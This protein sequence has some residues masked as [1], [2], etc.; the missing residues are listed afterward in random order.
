M[1]KQ[2]KFVEIAT[3]LLTEQ[4]LECLYDILEILE[5][6]HIAQQLV[7]SEK[8]P[9]VSIALPTYERLTETWRLEK[10]LK[11]KLLPFLNT[12]LDR[13]MEYVHLLRSNKIYALA[14]SKYF[15]LS[16]CLVHSFNSHSRN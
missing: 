7:S 15:V 9:T 2:P 16:L 6:L 11:P 10:I 8:T 13:M 3:H 1:S 5:V 14:M 4:Q 12:G